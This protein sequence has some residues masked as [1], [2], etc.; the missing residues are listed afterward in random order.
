MVREYGHGASAPSDAGRERDWILDTSTVVIFV[1]ALEWVGYILIERRLSP[2][3]FS[4]VQ[5]SIGDALAV[6][7]LGFVIVRRPNVSSIR[8]IAM[9][10]AAASIIL[11][12]F[13]FSYYYIGATKNFS[14]PLTRLDAFYVALG[15]LTTAGSGDIY[16]ISEKARALVSGQYVA[17]VILFSGLIS[18]LLW[19]FSRGR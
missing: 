13:S 2:S 10:V 18:F 7:W 12:N 3:T 15:N 8:A 16:P 5:Y 4:L 19:R 11:V 14:R 17:D 6:L 1:S 9:V